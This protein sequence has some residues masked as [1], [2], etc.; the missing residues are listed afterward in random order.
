MN[1]FPFYNT[2]HRP[3]PFFL[4]FFWKNYIWSRFCYY[5]VIQFR[6]FQ[7]NYS[8]NNPSLLDGLLRL[9]Y[10]LKVY[11]Y[12]IMIIN[13]WTMGMLGS[14]IFWGHKFFNKSVCTA[15]YGAPINAFFWASF[16]FLQTFSLINSRFFSVLILESSV[17]YYIRRTS[18]LAC[19]R[20]SGHFLCF[21][22]CCECWLEWIS[23]VIC[24]RRPE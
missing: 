23:R 20:V 12:F 13:H 1:H 10:L 4:F 5:R 3:F 18:W 21:F 2:I 24:H 14:Y 9:V 7:W 15:S 16:L 17:I 6:Y 8:L 11:S 19:F 22:G